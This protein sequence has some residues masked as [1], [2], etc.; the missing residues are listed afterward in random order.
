M[1]LWLFS[2]P[3]RHFVLLCICD[4]PVSQL[5]FLKSVSTLK[6]SIFNFRHLLGI[7]D[8]FSANE[9]AE[10]LLVD[11]YRPKLHDTMHKIFEVQWPLYYIH[12][13][14]ANFSR[15]FT[16]F[17]SLFKH[18]MDSTLRWLIISCWNCLSFPALWKV[19]LSK[20]WNV[21]DCVIVK[22]FHWLGKR[23]DLEQKVVRFVNQSHRW[24]PIRLQGSPVASKWM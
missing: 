1:K 18:L 9:Y 11:Y 21:I 4:L 17:S 16:G 22:L 19:T 6:H 20:P 5:N 24:E 14:I 12:F 15:S 10:F 8:V 13:E 2:S 7:I 23:C 3:L